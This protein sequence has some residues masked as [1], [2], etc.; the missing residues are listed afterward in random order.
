MSC[1]I[2]RRYHSYQGNSLDSLNLL[3]QVSNRIYIS[4]FLNKRLIRQYLY[5]VRGDSLYIWKILLRISLPIPR[6]K[7]IRQNI[8]I[9]HQLMLFNR[10]INIFDA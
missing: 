5:K 1:K 2:W 4:S 10:I 9:S 8:P 6:K 7:G 3:F